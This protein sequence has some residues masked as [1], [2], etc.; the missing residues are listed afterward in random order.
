MLMCDW[1]GLCDGIVTRCIS[2]ELMGSWW[3]YG[4]MDVSNLVFMYLKSSRCSGER[5]VHG[6]SGGPEGA[7]CRNVQTVQAEMFPLG[8]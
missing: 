5:G 6:G 1:H 7:Q 8:S 4:C 2:V 3:W